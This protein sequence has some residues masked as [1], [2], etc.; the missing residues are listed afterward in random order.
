M[1]KQ[2]SKEISGDC[3]DYNNLPINY[4]VL[5]EKGCFIEV[6]NQWLKTL[7]YKKKEVVGLCFSD[8]LTAEGNKIF[9]KC[10]PKFKKTGKTCCIEFDLIH[11]DGSLVYI[12]LNCHVE[13]D[14]KGKFKRSHCV[15]HDITEHK[16][17][18]KTL[19]ESEEKIFQLLKAIP[20]PMD[21]V[22]ENLNVLWVSSKM[23][24]IIRS[25]G[26]K[27]PIGKKCY[28]M[29][30][31]NKKQCENCPLKKPIK[32]GETKILETDC[33]FGGKTFEITHT[34]MIYEGKKV[35]L[36]VFKN[37]TEQKDTQVE[38][39]KERDRAQKYLDVAGVILVVIDANGKTTLINKKGCEIL[40]YKEKEIIGKNW[41]DQFVPKH[42][43]KDIKRVFSQLIAGKVKLVEYYEN[44]ILVK[45]GVEKIIAWHNT[46]LKDEKGKIIGILSSGEDVT[47]QKK[48]E[49]DLKEKEDQLRNIIEH[50]DEAFYI[51]DTKN[52]LIYI[53]PQSFRIFGYKPEEM[54]VKWISL[55][56][57]NP[58]NEIGLRLTEKAI[59]TG[60]KQDPYLL[61]F[62]RKDGK[63]IL[64]EIDESPMKD[65][66]GKVISMTG[67]VKDIT[68]RK[69]AED[70]L[71]E[72]EHRYRLL[73]DNMQDQVWIAE[74]VGLPNL[75]SLLK[76][77]TINLE[78]IKQKVNLKFIYTSPSIKNLRGYTVE[79]YLKK[80][81]SVL[82]KPESYQCAMK[83]LMEEIL[84]E[85]K[86]NVNLIRSRTLELEA[87]RKDGSTYWEEV[88]MSLIR[89]ENNVPV[90]ILGVARDVTKRREDDKKI[91]EKVE[92]MEFMVRTTLKHHKEML[93]VKNEN[94]KLKKQLSEYKN[95]T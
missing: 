31:D 94:Q 63:V 4:Q 5:N 88:K 46:V 48:I 22:D 83:A 92:Q 56:T 44:S 1:S 7:G 85:G 57:N 20:D 58:I 12:E 80:D 55:A 93:R 81:M 19:K 86:K 32:I 23:R 77:G 65:A 52:H 11:K 30:R 59:K 66:N 87:I 16:K 36:E 29:Y 10:F 6:S 62:K 73:A 28:S 51:H 27:N 69:M 68:E 21:I 2:K 76:K 39:Q 79:E 33:T 82:L 13:R 71:T 17:A 34:G 75:F 38:I 74:I 50:S 40:G 25:K 45:G 72:G 9:K 14:K 53:S 95:K 35:I 47:E 8:V 84:K 41:F 78:E 3:F 54:V 89:D 42:L 49:K 60:E 91:R 43:T 90:S 64:V 61:E 67:A 37:V 24:E 15:F 70:A 26:I 18:D